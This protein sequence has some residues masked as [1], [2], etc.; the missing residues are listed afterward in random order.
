MFC[1]GSIL[2]SQSVASLIDLKKKKKP[3]NTDIKIKQADPEFN[4]LFLLF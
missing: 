2:A 1:A 4:K 3:S